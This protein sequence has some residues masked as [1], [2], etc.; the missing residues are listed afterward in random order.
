MKKAIL[1]IGI[2]L[3]VSMLVMGCAQ[4][5]TTV[6][7]TSVKKEEPQVPVVPEP[8]METEELPTVEDLDVDTPPEELPEEEP[9]H[10]ASPSVSQEDLDHLKA[11]LEGMDIEDLG[12][13][14]E[15]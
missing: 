9:E 11:D 15:E 13:L 8:E 10:S 6:K 1:L 12:G 3:L 4:Q 7:S 2:L 5:D 14:S